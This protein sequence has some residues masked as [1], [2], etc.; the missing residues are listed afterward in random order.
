M[1]KLP[2]SHSQDTFP[3]VGVVVVQGTKPA[4][5]IVQIVGGDAVKAIEPL[6]EAAMIGVDV[7]DMDSALDAQACAQVGA[8]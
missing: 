1:W 6:F 2:K 5:V 7:L 8:S 3:R 4:Q